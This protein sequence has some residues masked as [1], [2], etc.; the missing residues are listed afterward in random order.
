MEKRKQN[1]G[2]LGKGYKFDADEEQKVKNLRMELSKGYGMQVD[3]E[4]DDEEPKEQN[5]LTEE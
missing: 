1:A 2:Y 4:S 3:K 5:G